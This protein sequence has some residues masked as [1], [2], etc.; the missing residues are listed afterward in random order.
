MF[1]RAAYHCLIMYVCLTELPIIVSSCVA[2]PPVIASA[3]GGVLGMAVLVMLV[4]V[5]VWLSRYCRRMKKV[6]EAPSD[7]GLLYVKPM[8]SH[9][10][11]WQ[12]DRGLARNTSLQ[13]SPYDYVDMKTSSMANIVSISWL[14][15]TCG[16]VVIQTRH[17]SDLVKQYHLLN[18]RI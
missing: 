14:A 15:Y 16:H 10:R 5:V 4:L 7:T 3:I 6:D 13:T 8:G 1:D 18:S 17:T 11:Y 12:E 2:G 9:T